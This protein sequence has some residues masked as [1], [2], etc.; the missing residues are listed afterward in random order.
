MKNIVIIIL[1]PLSLSVA[2]SQIIDKSFEYGNDKIIVNVFEVPASIKMVWSAY[3]NKEGFTSWAAPVAEVD[4][5]IGGVIRSSFTV[6]GEIG[7]PTTTTSY[8]VNIIPLKEIVIK[9]ELLPLLEMGIQAG[10]LKDIP[11]DF[12]KELRKNGSDIFTTIQLEAVSEENTRLTVYN[13]GYKSGGYWDIIYQNAVESNK[14]TYQKLIERFKN[15]P[16]DWNNKE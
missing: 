1:I 7:D 13:T 2:R 10:W 8:I 12:L 14:W 15:G 16:I 4:W 11:E 3:D 9:D 5:R 6:G